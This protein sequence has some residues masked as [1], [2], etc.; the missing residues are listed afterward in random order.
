CSC[1]VNF[2]TMLPAIK[3]DNQGFFLAAEINDIRADRMLAAEFAAELVV[4]Q[5]R[6]KHGFDVGLILT[7]VFGVGEGF[8]FGIGSQCISPPS[9]IVVTT[10]LSLSRRE[11][12][13]R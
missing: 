1:A 4:A 9:E 11:R 8:L 7:K 5:D 3:F 13:V 2:F 12:V 6:P 10:S